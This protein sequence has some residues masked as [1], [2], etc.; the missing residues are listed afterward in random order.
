MKCQKC[1]KRLK[2]NESFCT[3]CGFYNG[4]SKND[5]WKE[6]EVNLLEDDFPIQ[7]DEDDDTS[8]DAFSLKTNASG[9]KENEFYYENEE[10]LEAFI[11][12]D[13]KLIKKMPFNIYACLLNWMYFLYR[14]LYVT[15]IIGLLVT[16]LVI[17]FLR[18]YF[19]YYAIITVIILGFAFNPLYIFVSKLKVEKI[20][21]KNEGTDNFS[22][23][24]ICLEKGGV[25]VPIALVI[26]FIFLVLVF[27]SFVNVS[28]NKNHNTKYW[29]ENSENRATCSSLV[30]SAYNDSTNRKEIGKVEEAA[31]NVVKLTKQYEIYLKS[32]DS[33]KNTVY[34]YYL[35]EDE[36]LIYQSDTTKMNGLELKKSNGNITEEETSTLNKLRELE[37]NYSNISKKSKE[38][39]ELI[40]SKKN[41]EEKVNFIFSKTEIIQ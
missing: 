25:N 21:Q 14:K 36:Y 27:F 37:N 41:K 29:K 10:Y 4:E 6:E 31:C 18:S 9:T 15:G 16:L 39:D 23:K 30:K 11:G 19:L 33:N 40:K 5:D 34:T 20:K 38:E 1:G 7:D 17:N 8:I 28:V 13:Y 12:E 35:T 3:V 24:G 2:K 22:L 32:T 26:Y